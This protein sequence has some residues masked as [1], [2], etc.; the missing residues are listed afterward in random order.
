M[1]T[2]KHGNRKS[3]IDGVTK[4]KKTGSAQEEKEN[5]INELETLR[6]QLI[7]DK[8][9]RKRLAEKEI[10]QKENQT[11]REQDEQL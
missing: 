6:G 9:N 7:I 4:K 2:L 8:E 1:P 3:I 10:K 5:L 11:T